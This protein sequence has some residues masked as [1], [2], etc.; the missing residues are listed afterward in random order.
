MRLRLSIGLLLA[1]LVL[2]ASPV[3]SGQESASDQKRMVDGRISSLQ[4][5]IQ[6]AREREGVLSSEIEVVSEKIDALQNDVDAA[7][8][9]LNE[10]ETVL[11]L[12]QR[13]LDRLNALYELQTRKLVF[14][15]R[16]HKEAV[17]RL[18]KRLVEIYTSERTSSISVVLDSGSFSDML[19]Q[20]EFLNTIGRQ[21]HKIANEV[22][23]AKL[24][25][26]ETRNST[27]KTR[28][29]VAETTRCRRRANGRAARR[30]RPARLEP[31]RA[32][33][34]PPGQADDARHR[35]GRTRK[36]RSGTCA[37]CRRRAQRSGPRSAPR[38]APTSCLRPPAPHRPPA[39]S[40]RSKA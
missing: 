22:E 7:S 23:T 37:T 24:Q 12:H 16:Q 34:G 10:L 38:R 19:D 20:L 35:C 17:A 3:A 33:D 25:M 1:G 40:G 9:R 5:K 4:E 27:R 14:L 21:D 31:A 6:A 32:G 26:Q 2:L 29:Q 18:S 36:T 13:K 39:S 11:A 28:R 15:Q 30:P 8:A